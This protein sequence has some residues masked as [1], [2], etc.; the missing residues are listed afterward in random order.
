MHELAHDHSI[1]LFQ[2]NSIYSMIPKNACSTMRLSIGMA[3]GAI[4]EPGNWHW[5]HANNK[6]FRPSLRE[7]A[8][9]S[10]TFAILRCPFAR[11]VSCFLDKF[12]SRKPEA[13][14]FHELSGETVELARLTFRNF[15]MEMSKPQIKHSNIHWRPQV[16][17]LVYRHYD[18]LF[19]VEDF[20]AAAD[21][22]RDRIGLEIFDSRHLVRHDSSH[23]KVLP[24]TKSFADTEIWQIEAIMLSGMR[25]DPI[26][27]Y[28]GDLVE[29]VSAAYV[30]DLK[31]FRSLF[32]GK[33]LMDQ[34]EARD[35]AAIAS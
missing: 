22:L 3:N 10:Y 16:D 24:H 14:H 27:F 19:C 18:Q 2:S 32:H 30:E 29:L 17:F 15:C 4:G 9:A 6:T 23:Y 12:V 31:L 26:S 21:T 20:G 7:L 11:L 35:L 28:D 25:P 33:S 34:P 1:A 8:T 5:I 13:W